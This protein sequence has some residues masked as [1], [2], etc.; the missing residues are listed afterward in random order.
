MWEVLVPALVLPHVL[1]AEP[2]RPRAIRDHRYAPW[3]A[4]VT[5][6]FGAFM[7]QLDASIVTLAFPALQR[8]FGSGLA[9]VQWVS[10]AYLL[11]LVA[12]LV[13]LGRWSD[14]FGRK[15]AYLYG[16]GIFGLASA[17]CGLAPSVGVLIG[18][19]VVQAVGAALLQ[20]NSVALVSTSVPATS[21]RRALG[22]Q[23]V[24]QAAG[25]AFGPA[26]GGLIVATAG[27]RWVF[28]VNPPV[29]LVAGIAGVFLLPRTR[30]RTQGGRSDLAGA[31]L[32]AVTVAGLLA[33]ASAAAGLRIAMAGALALAGLTLAAAAALWWRERRAPDPLIS[34]RIVAAPGVAAGLAGALAAYLVLF[35]PLVL[36]PQVLGA[37]AARAD[38]GFVITAL[39]AGFAGGAVLAERLLP[40]LWD[41][42]RRCGLGGALAVAA[43]AVLALTPPVPILAVMLGM[44]GAG[45]GI[46]LPA[47][48]A[49]VMAAV[50]DA[51]AATAGGMVNM[52]RGI[53]TALG[54]AAVAVSLH[55]AGH[56]DVGVRLT[57]IV[58]AC[59]AAA[60]TAAS[61]GSGWGRA[62]RSS[63]PIR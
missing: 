28:L 38:A 60:A 7:G 15:L 31:I 8:A 26:A 54:V 42:R 14:R 5:I 44:L 16:F 32:L 41:H 48:N 35:A 23:A 52:A 3:L 22:V 9:A 25:L 6:C 39:P 58:L 4:V 62:G 1:T 57:M 18:C 27:W 2:A 63:G 55:V 45:L 30:Q 56:A 11:V 21:R 37:L 29:A 59:C 19:R 43:A 33:V 40:G 34:A 49:A 53:G 13:P 36:Y 46:Y 24:A 20:A 17:G 61:V 10:L 50:P 47:S 12:L 51:G